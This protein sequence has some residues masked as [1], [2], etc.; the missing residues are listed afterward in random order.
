[1]NIHSKSDVSRNVAAIF[2]GLLISVVLVIVIDK[3]FGWGMNIEVGKSSFFPKPYDIDGL[4]SSARDHGKLKEISG[5]YSLEHKEVFGEEVIFDVI[6]NFDTLY[7]RQVLEIPSENRK[8]FVMF[9]GGSQTF[10]EGLADGDTIPTVIQRGTSEHLVYNYAYKGYGPHQM[11]K[12]LENSTLLSEVPEKEGIAFFQYFGFHVHR[13]I[14]SMSYIKW[15]GGGAPYYELDSEDRLE[16]QG[17]FST[18]RPFRTLLYWVLSR[19]AIA[20][21]Y[22]VDIP[23]NITKHHREIT[24]RVLSKS[25]NIFLDQYPASRFVVIVGM[26][27]SKRDSIVDDCLKKYGIEYVDMRGI[28]KDKQGLKFPHNGHFTSR[29]AELIGQHLIPLINN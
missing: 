2:L 26:G 12:K 10:G 29:A 1:M 21:H 14:G 3:I 23:A 7:R 18:G 4:G 6:Y 17:S 24:C 28:D 9:F 19:S 27:N 25:R 11:L 8:Y 5:G 16:Y 20:S 13:V 22:R 15:A